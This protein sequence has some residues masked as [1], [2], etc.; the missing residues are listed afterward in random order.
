MSPRTSRNSENQYLVIRLWRI[1]G[2][3][4]AVAKGSFETFD[5]AI[6]V[7]TASGAAAHAD[8]ADHLTVNNDGDS[9][10]VGKETELHQLT[11]SSAR[12]V[13][14]L[15]VGD[16]GRPPRLQRRLRLQH[17]RVH[18]GI[19]LTVAALLMNE[20]PMRIENVDGRGA[21]FCRCPITTGPRNLL[22][23]F[24]GNLIALENVRCGLSRHDEFRR[25]R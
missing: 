21:A 9:S 1:H 15:S 17:S 16:R 22:C 4:D 7:A 19:N 6:L 10:G 13:A 5:G 20:L 12:I 2:Q 3:K 23:G 14:Q 25:Q 8:R 11:W 18:V 24:A